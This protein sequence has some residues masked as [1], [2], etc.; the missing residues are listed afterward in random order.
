MA[1]VAVCHVTSLNHPFW[2]HSGIT[3]T[4]TEKGI[5]LGSTI[6]SK[7]TRKSPTT[8][9]YYALVVQIG[10]CVNCLDTYVPTKYIGHGLRNKEYA[11]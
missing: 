4:C 11:P 9:L 5:G 2:H 8:E 10:V 6:C 1:C 3:T 7:R